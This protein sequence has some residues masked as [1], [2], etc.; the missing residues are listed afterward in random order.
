MWVPGS[1]TRWRHNSTD[2]LQTALAPVPLAVWGMEEEPGVG[3]QQGRKVLGVG[4]SSHPNWICG[5]LVTFTPLFTLGLPLAPL[6]GPLPVASQ[7][8]GAQGWLAPCCLVC[9]W[10]EGFHCW[11]LCLKVGQPSLACEPSQ[12]I[13]STDWVSVHPVTHQPTQQEA[14]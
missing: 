5:W 6:R 7:G 12:R 11:V 8:A 4:R 1:T 14:R 3:F 13:Q 2:W 10:C 9:Q